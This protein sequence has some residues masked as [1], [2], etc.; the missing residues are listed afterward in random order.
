MPT[1]VSNAFAIDW[2]ARWRAQTAAEH[3]QY[4][5][6]IPR[7]LADADFWRTHTTRLRAPV[8]DASR[9]PVLAYLL[10]RLQQGA[11]I[12][13][14]GCG[15]GRY[16]LPLAQA[17]M[18]VEAID[19]SPAMIAALQADAAALGLQFP[20]RVATWED[21]EIVP[22]EV[23]LCA[24]VLYSVDDPEP[25]LRK[26]DAAAT[27]QVFIVMGYEPPISWLTPY[28]KLV[29]GVDRIQL[30]GAID[31]LG[32][33]HQLGIQAALTPLG[34]RVTIGYDTH[35]DALASVRNWL[36][37]RPDPARD[38]RLLREIETHFEPTRTGFKSRIAPELAIISWSK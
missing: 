1:P 36:K 23:V 9:D 32:V 26:L 19:P 31:T 25:F 15:A 28:W 24:H 27:G 30:P 3:A 5:A 16:A 10:P 33:L 22:A 38:A 18:R 37:L 14:V 29:Y 6:L 8:N 11:H 21:T 34:K 2:L 35:E 20:A 7:E 12:L 17:G 4:D 13:D